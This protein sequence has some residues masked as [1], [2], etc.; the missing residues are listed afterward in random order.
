MREQLGTPPSR[1]VDGVD[2]AYVDAAVSEVAGNFTSLV[3][4][5]VPTGTKN[6][7]NET[8]FVSHPFVAKSTAVYRNGLREV[9]DVGYSESAPN[10][11]VFTTAPLDTDT[12]TVDYT[13]AS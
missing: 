5:E 7:S 13:V 12:L 2:K 6:G 8:F 3:T 11:I 4:G 1:P 10:E 9:L